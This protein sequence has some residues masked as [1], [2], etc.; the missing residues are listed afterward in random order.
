[1]TV[2]DDA[3]AVEAPARK[4][5]PPSMVE[6]MT[7][8]MD[9]FTGRTT[10]LSLE[11]VVRRTHLPRSTAHRIL[12]QLVRLRWLEHTPFGYG[13]GRRALG[14]GGDDGTRAEIR[15]A[16]AGR[17]HDLQ[18]RTGLVVHLAV[19]DEGQVH[20]LDKAGGR[21]AA[22]VPSWVGG[23]VPAH[24]TALGKAMLAW[25]E[26]EDVDSRLGETIGRL[27][28][29]TIADLPTLHQEL[30]RIRQ[31]RGLAFEHGEYF[32]GIAC[33][34][35]AVRGP[36]G[37][38]AA[39]SLAGEERTP[40]E[41][42]APLVADAARRISLELF[43]CLE[44]PGRAQHARASAAQEQNWSARTMDRLLAVGQNGDWL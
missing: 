5:L 23:R 29:R 1:M 27:T 10:R 30:N 34:A 26:P 12:E 14:L 20:Y 3:P 4:E 16:A 32:P 25:L 24:A 11:D 28:H 33:V 41:K 15:A 8:I 18:M 22:S 42:V 35:S 21:F 19:L 17:I 36:E 31:R 2:V 9:V 39:L 6:R 43:P 40:L 37:P 7:L 44:N 13:L 38:V